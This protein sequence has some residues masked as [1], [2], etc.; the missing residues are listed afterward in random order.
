MISLLAST[1]LALAIPLLKLPKLF[2][3]SKELIV[4]S[5]E[6]TPYYVTISTRRLRRQPGADLFGCIY[7]AMSS[8]A[9]FI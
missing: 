2:F 7:T 1:L 5:I 9:V 3:S 4:V 6:T 8:N